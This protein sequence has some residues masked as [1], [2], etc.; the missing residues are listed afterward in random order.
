ML[1]NVCQLR[2][3]LSNILRS[4]KAGGLTILQGIIYVKEY[5]YKLKHK[6][7]LII[8]LGEALWLFA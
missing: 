2:K 1:H 7:K 4:K 5:F 8:E 6:I 3:K